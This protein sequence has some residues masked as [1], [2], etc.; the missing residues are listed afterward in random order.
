MSPDFKQ[1]TRAETPELLFAHDPVRFTIAD[2]GIQLADQV[3][4]KAVDLS[5]GQLA[6]SGMKSFVRA[7]ASLIASNI[8]C[9]SSSVELDFQVFAVERGRQHQCLKSVPPEPPLSP[10]HPSRYE[11]RRRNTHPVEDRLRDTGIVCVPVIERKDNTL[12]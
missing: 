11:E 2:G 10:Y 6:K 8:Q 3:I 5:Y 4:E 7:Q 12:T 9:G 1:V